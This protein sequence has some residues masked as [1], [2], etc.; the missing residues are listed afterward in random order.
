VHHGRG[1]PTDALVLRAVDY[2]D[3]DRIVTLLTERFGKVAVLARS[4]RKSK[5]RFGG[6]LEPY[7]LIEAD[8]RLGRGEVGSIGQARV[9]RSFPG[10]LADLTRI[11]VAG[12]ALELVREAL[13]VHQPEPEILESTVVFLERLEKCEET[14]EELLLAFETRV[15]STLGFA[16]NLDTCARCGRRAEE[17]RAALFDPIV[18]S[19]VCRSCGG[20]KIHLCGTTRAR[21]GAASRRA[22][23][24]A[25]DAP[26]EDVVR[27]EARRAV[28]GLAEHSLGKPLKA[29]RALA[30]IREIP[31]G[32]GADPERTS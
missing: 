12:A 6:S 20:A 30:Q 13:P 5:K 25:A 10:I 29:S 14:K 11:A 18:G 31:A 7:A 24:E 19:I 26:W 28:L 21:L 9:K 4:A 3:A 1:Q 16:P 15:L 8:V 17:G 27:A 23:F 2:R 22:W 32:N